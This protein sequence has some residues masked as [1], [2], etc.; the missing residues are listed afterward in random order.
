MLVAGA[1][2]TGVASANSDEPAPTLV[3]R[4]GTVSAARLLTVDAKWQITLDEAGKPFVLPAGDVVRWG[5]PREVARGGQVLLAGGSVLAAQALAIEGDSLVVESGLFGRLKLPLDIVRAVLFATPTEAAARD[6]LL[7]RITAPAD[8]DKTPATDAGDRLLLANGDVLSGTI[9]GLAERQVTVKF[10]GRTQQATDAAK[11]DTDGVAAMV[12]NPELLREPAAEKGL[13]AIVGVNDGGRLVAASL[14]LDDQHARLRIGRDLV[15]SAASQCVVSLQPLGDRVTYLSDLRPAAYE[16][17]PYLGGKWPLA[18]D[19]SVAGGALRSGGALYV[20]GLGV[21]SGARVTYRLERPYA[22]LAADLAIDDHTAGKGSVVVRALVSDAE[23]A[24]EAKS[25]RLA[26]TSPVIRGG[27]PPVA[28]SVPLREVKRI[29][30]EIDYA[31]RGD[32]LDRANLLDARL[33]E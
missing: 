2:A 5:A 1:L 18:G 27:Q 11:V 33:I 13:R 10:V 19:R 20:K 30:L 8:G 6:R 9:T 25:W 4:D 15:L 24:D 29:R 26:Y 17:V 7:A 21:H 31:D 3:R 22:S 32:E 23:Q 12:F 16:F 28:M 14:E